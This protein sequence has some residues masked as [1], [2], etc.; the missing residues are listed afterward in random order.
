MHC[1]AAFRTLSAHCSFKIQQCRGSG[2]K[3]RDGNLSCKDVRAFVCSKW[4]EETYFKNV[5][6]A[7]MQLSKFLQ[8]GVPALQYNFLFRG[9]GRYYSASLA[10]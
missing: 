7:H 9:R 1:S 3:M 4:W 5:I 10:L 6:T 2:L 8:Y